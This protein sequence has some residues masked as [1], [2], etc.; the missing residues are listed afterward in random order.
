MLQHGEHYMKI[1]AL[2]LTADL[3]NGLN[4]LIQKLNRTP[5]HSNADIIIEVKSDHLDPQASEDAVG[6]MK[7]DLEPSSDEAQHAESSG[8]VFE[9]N[10]YDESESAAE[11]GAI[12]W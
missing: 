2:N 3:H 4:N 5:K 6:E 11:S 10:A 9:S 7:A 8:L 1:R 12:S